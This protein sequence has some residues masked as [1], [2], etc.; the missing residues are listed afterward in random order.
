VRYVGPVRLVGKH[1]TIEV[2]QVL[3]AALLTADETYALIQRRPV[4]AAA[5]DAATAPGDKA[6]GVQ[7]PT[8]V[9]D[10]P[11]SAFFESVPDADRAVT[12]F[13]AGAIGGL[14]AAYDSHVLDAVATF[15]HYVRVAHTA[16]AEVRDAKRHNSH[17][18]HSHHHPQQ[19][20]ATS[21]GGAAASSAASPLSGS[22]VADVTV[23]S[24]GA[25]GTVSFGGQ[26][27][28][29]NVP[30]LESALN[31]AVTAVHA[32]YEDI[33][34]ALRL[35]FAVDDSLACARSASGAIECRSK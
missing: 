18:H 13:L 10:E 27:Q 34:L 14:D 17:R 28:Q 5:S 35:L 19:A 9:P 1:D 8:H 15:N 11:S 26:L 4:A 23:T 2:C 33:P 30:S 7:V 25:A 24:S 31:E 6:E 32:A 21:A 22:P 16:A 12:N 29:Q 3:G 20:P